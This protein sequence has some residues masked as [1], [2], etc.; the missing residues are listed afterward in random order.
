MYNNIIRY[1][2]YLISYNEMNA[3]NRNVITKYIYTLVISLLFDLYK[4]FSKQ[5]IIIF[6]GR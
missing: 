3:L 6:F 2:R 5:Q 4:Y 1:V